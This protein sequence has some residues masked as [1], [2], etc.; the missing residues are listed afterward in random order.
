MKFDV[1]FFHPQND[2]TGSTKVLA[3]II[4]EEYHD[5]KVAVV[6]INNRRGFLTDLPVKIFSIWCPLYKG[7]SIPIVSS[8]FWR[9][10][11]FFLALV[12]GIRSDMFYINT[13]LPY[14]AVIVAWLFRKN[15]CYHIHEKAIILNKDYKIAEFVF[16]HTSARKVY[17]STYV[18]NQ[19]PNQRRGMSI[20][21]YNYLPKSYI[22]AVKIIP[23]DKRKRNT[24]TM[25]SS[26]TVAK[27]IFTF[28]ELARSLPRLRFILLVSAPRQKAVDFLGDSI[29]ENLL[30]V[31]EANNIH[32]YLQET[33]LILN[34]SIP[35]LS[36][37]TFGMTILEAMPYGIPAIVPN[38]GGPLE[39]VE[40]G[41]NGFC[42]VTTDV[43]VLMN[44]IC[45]CL[46]ETEYRRLANNTL[47]RY[48]F[49][50]S[51]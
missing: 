20:V 1:L 46:E 17:V 8:L 12:L 15:I 43:E 5:K 39:L 13:I 45:F 44:R 50:Y 28:L 37:E 6:T 27:G 31:G 26:L 33:D 10:H 40:N 23:V 30:I 36:V 3:N 47:N 19:Y 25:I 24:V 7:S 49:L 35:A 4:E 51:K 41:Y 14:Y 22:E 9:I 21:K 2:L 32:P 29:P 18:K 34:L 38:V 42:E 11:A 16:N 48:K